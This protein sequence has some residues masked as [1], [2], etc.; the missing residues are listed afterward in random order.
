MTAMFCKCYKFEGIGLKDWNTENVKFMPWMFSN[1]YKL[2]E[3]LSN[4]DVSEVKDMQSMFYSCRQFNSDLSN[5]KIKRGAER[6]GMFDNC[7]LD[8]KYYPIF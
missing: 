8:Q 6:K 2:K 1:C 4:W 3:D 7:P 5:W